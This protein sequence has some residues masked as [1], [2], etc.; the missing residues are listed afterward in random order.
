LN[1]EIVALGSLQLADKN[2]YYTF[3]A[4]QNL[5][6]MQSA[7]VAQINSLEPNLK[8]TNKITI[9][10]IYEDLDLLSHYYRKR[11]EVPISQKI[12]KFQGE[13]RSNQPELIDSS[14]ERFFYKWVWGFF[15]DYGTS[16]YKLMMCWFFAF[17]VVWLI[18]LIAWT[19]TGL[20]RS[21]TK[22]TIFDQT[23]FI[24]TPTISTDL[25]LLPPERSAIGRSLETAVLFMSL[26]DDEGLPSKSMQNIFRIFSVFLVSVILGYFIS[27]LGRSF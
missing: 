6:K 23:Y 8:I 3:T 24:P 4:S 15:T 7:I 19:G 25:S 10:E 22:F 12:Q 20:H 1:A 5:L 18:S 16:I 2:E 26:R 13:L 14:T 9:H 27:Y 17:G 11:G 21:A